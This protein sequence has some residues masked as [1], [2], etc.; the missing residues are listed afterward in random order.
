MNVLKHGIQPFWFW[1]GEMKDEEIQRQ[2][3]EMKKQGFKGFL[4]HPRQG[5][6][7][8]YLSKKFFKKV[9]LAVE[10]AKKQEMEVL[11]YDEFPY[12]SGVSGGK[13]T[14]DHPEYVCKELTKTCQVFRGGEKLRMYVGVK[15]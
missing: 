2:I 10:T 5:M 15:C 8:P 3:H 1:N 9:R 7:I 13:V 12:P 6:E 4:I 11:L 14:L